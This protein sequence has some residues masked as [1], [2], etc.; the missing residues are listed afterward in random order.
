MPVVL[1]CIQNESTF[2][3]MIAFTDAETGIPFIA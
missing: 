2:F 3:G 1:W